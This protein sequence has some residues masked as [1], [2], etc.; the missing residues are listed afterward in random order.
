MK[1]SAETL[2]N[3]KELASKL[4]AAGKFSQ[5]LEDVLGV[6]DPNT[7]DTLRDGAW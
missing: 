7:W 3:Y 5:D 2:K 6:G 4:K 1:Q